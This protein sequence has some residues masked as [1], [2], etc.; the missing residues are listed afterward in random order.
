MKTK[1]LFGFFMAI[2]SI[3]LIVA[4]ISAVTP[5]LATFD[6]VKIN[7]ISELGSEDI[8]VVAGESITVEVIFTALADA[9]DVKLKAE[10]EGD[11]TDVEI[12]L[13][14]GDVEEGIR[15]T[16]TFTL[17]VPY[18]LKDEVSTALS[19]NM[20]VWN[21]DYR[22]DYNEIVLRTQ[23][24]S[25]NVAVMSISTSQTVEAGELFPINVVLKNVGYNDL[26]DLYVTVKLPTLDVEKTVYA[27]DLY[28]LEDNDADEEDTLSLRAYLRVPYEA[29]SGI[30]NLEVEVTNDDL[31]ISSIKQIAVNND[32]SNYVV[33][34][35]YSK[36]FATGEQGV[37]N[38]LIVNPT[39]TI[40]VFRIMTESPGSLSTSVSESTVAVSPGTSKTVQ[41]F[42]E[43]RSQG[44][45]VFDVSILSGDEIVESV[46][47][48]ANVRSGVASGAVVVLTIV[49]LIIFLVLLVIL[50]VL[51]RKKP[52]KTD[53]F[54]ESYY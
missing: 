50:I 54:G 30:Y 26:D 4:T 24:P 2:A 36:M 29:Q 16:E 3:L 40:K 48:S 23:R 33:V 32:F 5:E 27:G 28:A 1:N 18:E 19:L 43:A 6:S 8:S 39:N 41:I 44:E 21:G 11:K 45:Y 15:Y 12:E 9:S 46:T 20:K 34:N 53:D 35:E 14:L 42:A 22:T 52:E 38:L 25:Y 47:L 49:L 13:F 10:L 37:Y 7:G 51:L 31:T 17:K